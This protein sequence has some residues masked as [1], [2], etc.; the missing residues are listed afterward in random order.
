MSSMDREV[1]FQIKNSKQT[2]DLSW[3]SRQGLRRSVRLK[4]RE[5]RGD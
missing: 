2:R 3:E 1:V 5:T 4:G